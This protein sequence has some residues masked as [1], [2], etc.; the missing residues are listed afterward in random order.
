M[1]KKQIVKYFLNNSCASIIPVELVAA[2]VPLDLVEP[3]PLE[4]V[5]AGEVDAVAGQSNLR[6]VQGPD[7]H[8]R[9]R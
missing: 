3:L 2:L 5:V 9:A 8:S 7:L 6:H 1:S 4:V